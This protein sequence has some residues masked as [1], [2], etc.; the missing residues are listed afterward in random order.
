[1]K[2]ILIR[3]GIAQ[4]RDLALP[5][6]E[7]ELTDK[8]RRQV[9]AAAGALVSYLLGQTVEL[10]SSDLRRALQTAEIFAAA[11][12]GAVQTRAFAATGELAPLAELVRTTAADCL[13][14]VGHSP[15]LE[16][17]THQ[18]T[19]RILTMQKG[20][21]L[22]I[23]LTDAS[24]M[25]GRVN[26]HLPIKKYDRLLDFESVQTR[27]AQMIQDIRTVINE[28]IEEIL[29]FRE[30][31]LREPDEIESVH[32]LRVRIRQ[33]RS[34]VSFFKPLMTRKT[35]KAIQ[36]TL[37]AMAQEC[38]YLREL[39]VLIK[40]WQKVQPEM[41][42]FDVSGEVFLDLMHRERGLEARRLTGYLEK[43]DFAMELRRIQ[44]QIIAAIKPDRT[45]FMDLAGMVRTTLGQWHQEI[46]AGYEAIDANDL[47][48]IHALRIRA[49]KMRYLME[50]FDLNESGPGK[51]D[52]RQ[53]KGWQEVLGDL[54]DANRNA[55]AVREIAEKYPDEPVAVEIEAFIRI[56]AERSDQLYEDFFGRKDPSA[57]DSPAA[58]DPAERTLESPADE[59]VPDAAEDPAPKA[60]PAC[61]A[62]SISSA[63][64]GS[65]P[66][67]NETETDPTDRDPGLP[68]AEGRPGP[69][70][71]TE[72]EG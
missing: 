52:Y 26:W 58:D 4:D 41:A 48:V 50:I 33:F 38:A 24:A 68:A 31:Y 49:K 8:G 69:D 62:A 5:D 46:Q 72:P 44:G 23:E 10:I 16:D 43:P 28:N 18:M 36:N 47:A 64:E 54:T 1:M 70:A 21:A 51:N 20:A 61:A 34:L 57:E 12:L 39:D 55:E 53:I 29:S 25:T 6:G 45:R 56:Q 2:I 22:E 3:H 40:E 71:G 17:W 35:Q 15:H 11:G 14:I 37:R 42:S 66:A 27:K 19:D 32:K 13:V 9:E 60:G 63:E 67:E 7:R 59:A 30:I 65:A